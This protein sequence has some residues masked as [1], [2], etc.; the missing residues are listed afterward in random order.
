[1][2]QQFKWSLIVAEWAVVTIPFE[3]LMG[4]KFTIYIDLGIYVWLFGIINN[5]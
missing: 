5:S 3:W 2:L 4:K 1:M